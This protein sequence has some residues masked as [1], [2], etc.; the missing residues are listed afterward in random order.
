MASFP[1]ESSWNLYVENLRSWLYDFLLFAPPERRSER[2]C[3]DVATSTQACQWT[4]GRGW[5]FALPILDRVLF[6]VSALNRMF[7]FA[8]YV[9]TTNVAAAARH[10]FASFPPY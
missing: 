2:V 7:F 8:D 6:S 10:E 9:A 3:I 5:V 4:L 1:A